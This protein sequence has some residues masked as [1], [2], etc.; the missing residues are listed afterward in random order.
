[1]VVGCRPRSGLL[2]GLGNE[3][4]DGK[5]RYQGKSMAEMEGLSGRG[6]PGWMEGGDVWGKGVVARVGW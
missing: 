3:S 4:G 6:L 1:M 2:L 5:G